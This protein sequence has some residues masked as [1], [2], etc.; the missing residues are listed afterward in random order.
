MTATHMMA[1]E[2]A[3]TL[4]MTGG[5][6]PSGRRPRTRETASRTSAAADS[7]LRLSWNSMLTDERSFWLDERISR[8]PSRPATAPSMISVMRLSTTWFEAPR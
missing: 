3:S 6:M 1:P 4:R 2:L 5:S 7:W 8:M